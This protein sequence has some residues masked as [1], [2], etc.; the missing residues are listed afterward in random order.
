MYQERLMDMRIAHVALWVIDLEK[1][2]AFYE[3]YFNGHSSEKYENKTKGFESYFISFG[4]KTRLEVMRKN[5][6]KA[7]YA[8]LETGWAHIAFSVGSKDRVN[9]LSE[10]L[11]DDGYR[12]I[13]R[14]RTTGDGYYECVIEDPEGN[15]VELTE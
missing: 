10:K 4:S 6:V 7:K 13:S 9:A 8:P 12:L 11:E 15:R 3:H 1:E 14:P 2:K 5:D